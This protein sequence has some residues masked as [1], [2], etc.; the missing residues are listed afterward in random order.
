M[1]PISPTQ[2]RAA[3]MLLEIEQT[4]LARLSKV[5]IATVKRF[6]TEARGVGEA[7]VAAMQKAAED[8]G[9]VFI[10]DGAQLDGKTIGPGAALARARSKRA[11]KK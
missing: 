3:R 8:A 2:L 9:I 6:E 5:S 1:P 10:P 7:L 4:E 11:A